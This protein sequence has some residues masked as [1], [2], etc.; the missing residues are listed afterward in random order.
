[1]FLSYVSSLMYSESGL[2]TE[3][4]PTFITYGRFLSSVSY[5]M[6]NEGQFS[7]Q[8][9]STLT[10]FIGFL[11]CMSSLC[12]TRV[13]FLEKVL[14]HSLHSFDF[15]SAHTL[16]CVMSCPSEEGFPPF[17]TVKRLLFQSLNVLV[18]NKVFILTFG[19]PNWI[20]FVVFVLFCFF[21]PE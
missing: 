1:M 18:Q 17:M 9:F 13:G 11:P 21:T 4:C 8:K 14:L 12:T 20:I 19:F 10:T 2:M 3:K 5:L 6:C 15:L 16:F 7:T